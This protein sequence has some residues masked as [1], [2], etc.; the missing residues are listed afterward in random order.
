MTDTSS[1]LW[2][3]AH[4]TGRS[5]NGALQEAG[6]AHLSRDHAVATSD[7]YAMGWQAALTEQDLGA[8]VGQDESATFGART[9]QAH[10][11]GT[12]AP[13]IRAEQEKLRAADLLVLQFPLW[14]GGMP[15][16]LK[17]WVDRVFVNGFAFNVTNE[18][19]RT[20]KY[21]EG[22]L[23][24]KRA[25]VVV[26]AGDRELSFA[27]GGV[28]GHL[29]ALLFPVLHGILWYTG[30]QPLRPHL[31]AATDRREFAGLD[32]E[33]DR[34]LARL[35]HLDGEAPIDYRTLRHGGYDRDQR[36]ITGAAPLDLGIHECVAA[37]V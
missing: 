7:L 19:G 28:N 18:T 11:N 9:R 20:L 36:L 32:V 17:G 15:A 27:A 25:L 4:P 21:G 1:T 3:S 35:D 14:W 2:I 22:G 6:V 31:I 5:L 8:A 10:L 26:T 16:I 24:G 23:E 13:E 29:E 12:L 37:P 33:R 30:I 34:L